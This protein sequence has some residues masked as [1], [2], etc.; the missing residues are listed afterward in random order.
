MSTDT[1]VGGGVFR[2]PPHRIRPLGKSNYLRALLAAWLLQAAF[3]WAGTDAPAAPANG[4]E[5]GSEE[6]LNRLFDTEKQREASKRQ[7]PPASRSLIQFADR[8]GR[9]YELDLLLAGD[10]VGGWDNEAEH[11]TENRLLVREVEL[12]LF[13]NVDH[14]A[15]G[16]VTFAAHHEDG[17]TVVELHEA[18]L[19]FPTFVPRSTFK[20]GKFF[21]DAGRLNTI[22][23]HDWSFTNAP[24]VHEQLLGE[25]GTADTGLEWHFLMPWD[26]WQEFSVGVFNGETFGHAHG[27]G[28][29]KQNPL[30]TVRLKQFFPFWKDWGTQFGFSWLRW[31]P[32]EN[33]NRVTQQSGLDLLVKWKRGRQSS[34]QWLSEVWYRETRETRERPFDRPGAPVETFTGAYTFFEYQ[35]AQNWAAGLRFD[36]FTEPNKRGQLGYTYANG[37]VAESLVLTYSPSEFSKLRISG[38]RTTDVETGE[39]TYQAYA[40]A[41]F[42][43]GYH[44]AHVY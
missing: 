23:R 26:F 34:F 37:T 41:T 16:F 4:A 10:I 21:F 25:E 39:R 42:I 19:L 3:L 30:F 5:S 20:L 38:E 14:L 12:G 31:H 36:G 32:D 7:E 1:T 18:F 29:K 24:I 15:Q 27:E 8:R 6:E 43:L 33:P 13:A 35:F 40:Q 9:S 44:P 28:P 22:H 17:E 11:T 2:R